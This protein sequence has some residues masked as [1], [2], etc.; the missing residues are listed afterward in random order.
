VFAFSNFRAFFVCAR[1]ITFS[2]KL[3]LL[4]SLR[5]RT[6]ALAMFRQVSLGRFAC[7]GGS[8][9]TH[10]LRLVDALTNVTLV[11]GEIDLLT[12]D[13]LGDANGYVWTKTV[14]P[15][16]ARLRS[17][18]KYFLVSTE[19]HGGDFFADAQTMVQSAPG[20]T[21]GFAS[22]VFRT[23][24]SPAV[25]TELPVDHDNGVIGGFCYGPL[26]VETAAV[27]DA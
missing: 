21:R 15:S 12:A 20:A 5:A 22:P 13:G 1:H 26:N 16:N 3:T 6:H 7:P 8:S 10:T 4:V 19:T 9:E 27:V 24:A 18:V 23:T 2:I 17:G 14:T 11:S 25:W